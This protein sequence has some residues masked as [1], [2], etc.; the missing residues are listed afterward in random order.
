MD[1][2]T[3]NKTHMPQLQSHETT[4]KQINR[5]LSF[6]SYQCIVHITVRSLSTRGLLLLG[7]LLTVFM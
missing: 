2:N 5:L 1:G 4:G 7:W 6:M 3:L